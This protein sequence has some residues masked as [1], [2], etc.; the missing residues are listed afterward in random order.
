MRLVGW[1]IDHCGIDLDDD[2]WG[3]AEEGREAREA[4]EGR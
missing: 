4:R 1:R 3:S 2:E